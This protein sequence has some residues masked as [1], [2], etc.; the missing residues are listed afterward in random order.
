MPWWA[1][2]TYPGWGR[3]G[4]ATV[5]PRQPP[6][7]EAG[8]EEGVMGRAEESAGQEGLARTEEWRPGSTNG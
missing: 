2:L 4:K 6:A 3:Q 5:A 8:V 1:R 7:H